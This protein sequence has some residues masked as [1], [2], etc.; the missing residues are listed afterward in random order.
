M[1][2]RYLT[3]SFFSMNW[4]GEPLVSYETVVNLIGTTKTRTGLQ[5]KAR[6]D[7][8]NTRLESRSLMRR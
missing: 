6:L 7:T 8:K 4:K 1:I 3:F 5:V 2:M